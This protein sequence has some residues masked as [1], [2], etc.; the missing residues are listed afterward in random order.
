[1]S[2]FNHIVAKAMDYWHIPGMA[3]AVVSADEIK[4]EYTAG[5]GSIGK[6]NKV[7]RHTRF[8]MASGTKPMTSAMIAV[9]ADEGIIDYDIPVKQYIKDFKLYDRAATDAITLRDILCHRSGICGHDALWPSMIEREEFLRRLEYI[10][11]LYP[12]RYRSRYSNVM[13]TAAGYIVQ[14]ITGTMWEDLMRD[15][16]LNPLGMKESG[17]SAKEMKA[18]KDH[19]DGYRWDNGKLTEMPV[20]EL[21]GAEPAASLYSNLNDMEKWLQMHLNM[22]IFDGRRIIS[23]KNMR[24]MYAPHM[25]LGCRPW[26]FTELPD[27]AAFALGWMR[28][29]Y[30]GR[31]LLYHFGEIEGYCS[32]Q[33]LIPEIDRGIAIMV[34]RHTDCHGFLYTILL[35]LID[36]CMEINTRERPQWLLRLSK[37][38][39]KTAQS[40]NSP[41][42][43]K[44]NPAQKFQ[45]L[46]IY[47][48]TYKND[49]YGSLRVLAED[50]KLYLSFGTRFHEL[51]YVEKHQ[52]QAE[53]F[54]EDVLF[55]NIPVIFNITARNGQKAD[56]FFMKLEPEVD[57]VCFVRTDS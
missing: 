15:K 50:G 53:N 56:S 42:R 40:L 52:W 47:A 8:A 13:Y 44:T 25:V 46:S 5:V 12:F 22:G 26:V 57:A 19:A 28:R 1:M 33:A 20:W 36:E 43:Q 31:T 27:C 54:K 32:L 35:T 30:R 34:N 41:V 39:E 37:A 10:Q 23:E 14:H 17:F 55:L 18:Q 2:E 3:A 4:S 38:E 21:K 24:Q 48:G 6:G 16:I 11:P 9:L 45:D 49:G 29:S 7:T 51:S